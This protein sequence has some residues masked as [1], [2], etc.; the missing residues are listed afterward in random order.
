MG[1]EDVQPG[2]GDPVGIV[3]V[4][5]R[6]NDAQVD[7][8]RGG[9]CRRRR[10]GTGAVWMD[11][12]SRRPTTHASR[13]TPRSSIPPEITVAGRWLR[14][15]AERR[16]ERRPHRQGRRRLLRHRATSTRVARSEP[17]AMSTAGDF[18]VHLRAPPLQEGHRPREVAAPGL[19]R[20]VA[21][22]VIMGHRPEPTAREKLDAKGN[23]VGRG[24]RRARRGRSRPHAGCPSLQA[25]DNRVGRWARTTTPL[26]F[27]PAEITVP[28]GTKVEWFND[29]DLQHDVVA[30]DGSFDSKGLLGKGQKFEFTFTK[31]GRPSS[32]S[33][34]PHKDA[35]M[36][37][38]SR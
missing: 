13:S 21:P 2:A 22:S 34:R 19:G 32:T 35:G 3:R 6:K 25:A 7:S 23:V 20:P 8:G 1:G 16:P 18:A 26:K 24:L 11:S 17:V 10:P 28:V 38:S 31:A 9:S 14:H 37:G 27:L 12:P 5:G 36:K 15:L 33:A 4:E 29:T 30:E